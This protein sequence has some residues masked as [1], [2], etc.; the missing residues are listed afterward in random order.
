MIKSDSGKLQRLIFCISQELIP[1]YTRFAQAS[2][3]AHVFSLFGGIHM[4]PIPS[5]YNL[6]HGNWRVEVRR[7]TSRLLDRAE[8][9]PL[10]GL[11]DSVS[12]AASLLRT[13]VGRHTLLLVYNCGTCESALVISQ[14]DLQTKRPIQR[15]ERDGQRYELQLGHR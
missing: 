11:P 14:N 13:R 8:S 9:T 10:F 1:V 5:E 2:S 6:D 4:M 3:A 7:F 12:T 15:K